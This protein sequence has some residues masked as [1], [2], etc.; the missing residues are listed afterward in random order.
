MYI[1]YIYILCNLFI[2]FQRSHFPDT[3]NV[4]LFHPEWAPP[5]GRYSQSCTCNVAALMA[6]TLVCACF[7]TSGRCLNFLPMAASTCSE[8]HHQLERNGLIFMGEL[9]WVYQATTSRCV[10]G[11]FQMLATT[12]LARHGRTWPRPESSDQTPALNLA[13]QII[14]HLCKFISAIFNETQKIGRVPQK[15][16]SYKTIRLIYI[17]IYIYILC[18]SLQPSCGG[19]RLCQIGPK[20]FRRSLGDS[21]MGNRSCDGL[22]LWAEISKALGIDGFLMFFMF[23]FCLSLRDI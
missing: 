17:H 20:M 10:V 21:E 13:N 22:N 4:W 1:I 18:F 15:K 8:E 6:R 5:K 16:Q 14:A 7:T 11:S 19:P 2:I 23:I 12:H 9:I 3:S